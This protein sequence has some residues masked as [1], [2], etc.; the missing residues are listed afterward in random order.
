MQMTTFVFSFLFCG[1]GSVDVPALNF[2]TVSLLL[3]SLVLL[4]H[5]LRRT[6]HPR[7]V[8]ALLFRAVPPWLRAGLVGAAACV[9]ER[10]GGR[11]PAFSRHFTCKPPCFYAF[12]WKKIDAGLRF[13]TKKLRKTI[14]IGRFMTRTIFLF[15]KP[16][17]RGRGR[18]RVHGLVCRY[19][20]RGV[21]CFRFGAFDFFFKIIFS[22]FLPS[23]VVLLLAWL[24]SVCCR[25]CSRSCCDWVSVFE[26]YCL[27]HS[28]F[29]YILD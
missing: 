12:L 20:G 17:I 1:R 9:K 3:A 28:Q 8:L 21:Q 15:T 25:F 18:R 4:S 16:Q 29:F 13:D 23:K 26:K 6:R 22:L 2:Y 10:G 5:P 7:L 24:L 19:Q 11:N 14:E 27:A